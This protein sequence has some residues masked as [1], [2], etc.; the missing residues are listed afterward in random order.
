M[1]EEN[2]YDRERFEDIAKRFEQQP[3]QS[4]DY[5]IGR[6]DE[7]NSPVVKLPWIPRIGPKLRKSF[8]K[9]DVKVVFT[10]GP[11]LKDLLCQHKCP[12]PKNSQPGVYMLE[13]NCS[14][15]YIGETKMR[16]RTRIQQHEKDI[17][18]GR[19]AMSVNN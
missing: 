17:L 9:H 12:L 18:N 8:K 10:S 19:W 14:N 4:P 3:S 15:I 1:F 7:D 13:C 2:G 5:I 16:V 6:Q 11:S